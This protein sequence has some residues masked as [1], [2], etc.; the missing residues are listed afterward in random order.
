MAKGCFI[1]SG[2]TAFIFLYYMCIASSYEIRP[3]DPGIIENIIISNSHSACM[4]RL[5]KL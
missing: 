3:F 1:V 4:V 5:L 2:G